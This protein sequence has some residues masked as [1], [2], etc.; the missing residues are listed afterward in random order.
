MDSLIDL[1]KIEKKGKETF[2]RKGHLIQEMVLLLVLVDQE[3]VKVLYVPLFINH[4][5]MLIKKCLVYSMQYYLSLKV[6]GL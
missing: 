6:Y 2:I 3:K 4:Y 5:M 1:E